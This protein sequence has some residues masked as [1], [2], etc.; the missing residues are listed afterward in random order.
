VTVAVVRQ[1]DLW[2]KFQLRLNLKSTSSS[3][4]SRELR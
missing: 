3:T 1:T 2:H 4:P